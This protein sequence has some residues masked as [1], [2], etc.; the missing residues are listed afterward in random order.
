[1]SREIIGDACA[2]IKT[3]EGQPNR[4]LKLGLAMK[5]GDRLSL[6]LDTLPLPGCGWDGWI[7]VFPHKDREGKTPPAI[8]LRTQRA[9]VSEDWHNMD[10]DIPF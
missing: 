6:K 4:Y 5:E 3:P 8:A 1:M 2:F 10:D 9:A 7:N